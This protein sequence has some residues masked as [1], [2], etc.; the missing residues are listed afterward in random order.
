[1]GRD[2]KGVINVS[3][4]IASAITAEARVLMTAFKNIPGINIFYSDTDSA[5]VDS[6]LPSHL[7]GKELG[8][9]KLEN[10]LH[11]AIFL[12]PKVYAGITEDGKEVIK[13]KGLSA[14][15]L[16]SNNISFEVLKS[17]LHK[18]QELVFNQVKSFKSLSDASITLINQTYK[19][20]PTENKRQLLYNNDKILIGTKPLNINC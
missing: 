9:F 15:S 16:K 4:S 7:V 10:I 5:Y 18:D 11:D 19:L 1:M 3:V 2:Y 20:V 8:L 12:A 13:I 6:I 14:K 17:L